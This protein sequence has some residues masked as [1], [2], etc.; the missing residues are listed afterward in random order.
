MTLNVESMLRA[1]FLKAELEFLKASPRFAA[2]LP[3]V[4]S[5]VQFQRLCNLG[6]EL[7]GEYSRAHPSAKQLRDGQFRFS[8]RN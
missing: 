4:K 8:A 3:L 2:A 1:A 6:E 7:L 5:P